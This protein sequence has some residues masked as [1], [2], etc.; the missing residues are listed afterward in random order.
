MVYELGRPLRG[1]ETKAEAEAFASI[2]KD[3]EVQQIPKT[4]KSFEEA[5]F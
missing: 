1:F 4:Y 2:D 3:F 5:P